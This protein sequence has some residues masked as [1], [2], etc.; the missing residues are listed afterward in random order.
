MVVFCIDFKAQVQRRAV[1]PKVVG[2]GERD[3]VEK[4]T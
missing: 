3:E 2:E 1:R 4:A